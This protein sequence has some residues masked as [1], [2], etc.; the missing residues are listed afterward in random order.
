MSKN[1]KNRRLTAGQIFFFDEIH[2]K[3]PAGRRFLKVKTGAGAGLAGGNLA[4][5]PPAKVQPA[6]VPSLVGAP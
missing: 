2:L 5:K 6:P 1:S 3:P 4:R